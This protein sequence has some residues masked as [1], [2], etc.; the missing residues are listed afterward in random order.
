MTAISDVFLLEIHNRAFQG[1]VEAHPG[2]AE[3]VY[4]IV[5][6]RIMENVVKSTDIFPDITT[7]QKQMLGAYP[8]LCKK[9]YAGEVLDLMAR[10]YIRLVA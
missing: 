5:R 10:T 4:D 8:A 6:R 9:H 3:A 2:L 1:V 7:S